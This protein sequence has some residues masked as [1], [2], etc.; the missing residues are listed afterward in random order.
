MSKKGYVPIRTCIGCRK[1][2]KKE[3]MIWL[4]QRPEGVV[5]VNGKKTHQ[6][7]GFYLCR[8][9]GCLD[10][11]KKKNRGVGFLQTIDF[12]YPSAKGLG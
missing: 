3:E 12:R 2:R 9:L 7:R 11:A 10:M 8:D 4:V 5:V 6:G 1:K